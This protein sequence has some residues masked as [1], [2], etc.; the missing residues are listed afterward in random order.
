MVDSFLFFLAY[1]FTRNSRLKK[2]SG[3]DGRAAKKLP[4]IEELAV[5][6]VS[7]A[8][9]KFFTTP[10]QQIVTRKQTAASTLR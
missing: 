2:Y 6:M 10:V 1:N 4:V 5:G 3:A 7:G 9:S 8:F